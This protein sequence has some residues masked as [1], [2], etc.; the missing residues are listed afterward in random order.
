M[1]TENNNDRKTLYEIIADKLEEMILNDKARI[2]KK[3]PS[4]QRLAESFSVSRPVIREALKLVK[5]RGLIESRQGAASVIIEYSPE[6]LF[7]SITRFTQTQNTRPE[8]IHQVRTALELL[9]VR[10]ASD[11][12][13]ADDVA[14]LKRKN[15]VFS[16]DNDTDE[17][18]NL[19]IAFHKAIVKAGKNTLLEV[20][21]NALTDFIKPLIIKSCSPTTQADG[22]F[23]HERIINAI[24]KKD[25]DQAVSLMQQHLLLSIRNFEYYNG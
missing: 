21:Y 4:E 25:T 8:E 12:A 14:E 13:T 23:W 9:A 7:K 15:K 17:H 2:D 24:E 5:E 19:D 18:A 11:N 22:V 10:N 20:I 16:A 1:N 3:L 6:Q